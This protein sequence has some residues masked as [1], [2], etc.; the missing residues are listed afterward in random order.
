MTVEARAEKVDTRSKNM[1]DWLQLA[2]TKVG[3]WLEAKDDLIQKP[4]ADFRE[5]RQTE[6]QLQKTKEELLQQNSSS[7]TLGPD[8]N[9]NKNYIRQKRKLKRQKPEL[10]HLKPDRRI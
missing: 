3:K 9:C 4:F 6:E 10:S 1:E 8:K 7:K 2:K 5:L